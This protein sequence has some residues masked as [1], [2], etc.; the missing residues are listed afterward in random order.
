[1]SEMRV[2]VIEDEET[3]QGIIAS[4]LTRY[5]Q[6]CGIQVEVKGLRDAVMGLYEL[7][8]HGDAY[9]LVVLDVRMPAMPG[10]DIYE[11]L[12]RIEPDLVARVMFVTGY[13]EE[14]ERRFLARTP[15]ILDKPFRYEQF[16]GMV[17]ELV[18]N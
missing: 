6:S 13:R 15:A 16:S 9:D 8:T 2:L 11:N 17:A 7:T 1:M 14:I 10:D 12:V 5:G 4:F 3:I 18:G